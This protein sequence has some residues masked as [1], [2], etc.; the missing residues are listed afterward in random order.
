[1]LEYEELLDSADMNSD[2]WWRIAKDIERTYDK[3]D[4]FLVL[5]GT[6]S[7]A[8]IASGLSFILENLDKPVVLTGSQ[9]PI[10]EVFNDARRN[11]IVAMIFAG[12]GDFHEVCVCVWWWW[13]LRGTP[14][15]CVRSLLRAG[16]YYFA[17][18]VLGA[19]P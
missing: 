18:G 12:R 15:V 1:M 6:D 2:D 14:P 19:R 13:G 8:Y 16:G 17:A 3:Y 10:C 9:I 5:T 4:G 11:L 7:M